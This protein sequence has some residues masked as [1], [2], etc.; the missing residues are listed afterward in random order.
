MT[1][2]QLIAS[3]LSSLGVLAA[4]PAFGI[5]GAAAKIVPILGMVAGLVAEGEA[6]RDKIKELD[7]QL[8][9]IVATGKPPGD[10]AWASWS[11]RHE[12]A[13]ARLQA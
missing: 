10:E 8:K 6:A 1:T 11:A 13:K 2:F 12:A 9:D 5:A 4:N 7:Q 3:I